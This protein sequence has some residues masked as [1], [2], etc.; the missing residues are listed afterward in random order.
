V[1]MDDWGKVALRGVK[2]V[3]ILADVHL[4]FTDDDAFYAALQYGKDHGAD[5]I[6]LNGDFMDFYQASYH[7]R[8]PLERNMAHERKLGMDTLAYIRQEFPGAQIV[9]KE[10]NHEE[11]WR[12]YIWQKAPEV[13]GIEAFD[14]PHLMKLDRWNVRWVDRKRPIT[15]GKLNVIHGHEYQGGMSGPVNPA[16]TLFLK[17]RAPAICGHHHK[18]AEHSGRTIND[19]L[20]SC[21]STGWLGRRAHYSPLNDWNH[22]FA[23][24]DLTGEDDF[25]VHNKRIYEGR[26][27]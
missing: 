5:C 13:Y 9:W 10:G 11:R 14:I 20:I 27:L 26:V 12:R 18:T 2:R 8:N 15:V 22:G 21:W 17:A 23:L 24:V 7:E 3:L 19:K 25:T 4:P 16:R 1:S 6:L